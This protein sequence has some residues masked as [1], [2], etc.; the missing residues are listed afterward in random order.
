MIGDDTVRDRMRPVC[1]HPRRLGRGLDQAAE[2]VDVV[3][4][5]LALQYGRDALKPHA[6]VD[7]RTR[8]Q[9]ALTGRQLLVLHK[10]QVPD[11]DKAVAVRIAAAGRPTGDLRTMI[12]E[13]LG[14]WSARADIAHRPEIIGCRDAD[15]AVFGQPGDFRPKLR[16]II[17]LGIDRDEQSVFWQ[18]KI[19]RD[20]IPGQFDRPVL[21]VIAKGEIPEHLEKRMMPGRYS[22]R[23]QDRCAC[24]RRARIS[25]T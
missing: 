20:Q 10:D 9:H 22:R 17:V 8:Q 13:N 16:R 19:A 11:L 21:E 18:A 7:R 23:F 15:Y 4:I 3:I 25:A 24:R 1:R 14:A 6:G 2:Q 12:P 5:V